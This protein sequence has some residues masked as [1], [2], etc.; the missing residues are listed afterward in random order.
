MRKRIDGKEYDARP[1]LSVCVISKTNPLKVKASLPAGLVD[2]FVWRDTGGVKPENFSFAAERNK[3]VA[4]AKGKWILTM[5]DEE[6]VGWLRN[7]KDVREFLWKSD[8]D[9]LR[10]LVKTKGGGMTKS[11]RV[12]RNGRIIYKR[13]I[14][15][16]ATGYDPERVGDLSLLEIHNEG[17]NAKEKQIERGPMYVRELEKT[18]EDGDLWFRYAQ[19]RL[20]AEDWEEA[21]RAASKAVAWLKPGV[22]EWKLTP[23]IELWAIR[24][25]S[26]YEL[27]EYDQVVG[28][29]DRGLAHDPDYF[30]L[31]Y[32]K[33]RALESLAD[34]Q[35]EE[36]RRQ[37]DRF[38]Q[39]SEPRAYQLVTA[40]LDT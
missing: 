2:D 16:I 23:Y 13:A 8:A 17:G 20:I 34:K 3:A 5:D 21:I 6:I 29:C 25:K 14:R 38:N 18:P 27:G 19:N 15:N 30:D 4:M 1:L 12:F 40:G 26:R 37:K 11:L 28:I 10:V 33:G 35:Y 22:L 9:A 36:W 7:V 24:A 39:G 32:I 31:L